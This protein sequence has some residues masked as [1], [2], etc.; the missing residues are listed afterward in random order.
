MTNPSLNSTV[1][2]LLT[3]ASGGA[4][5]QGA[6]VILDVTTKSFTT[7]T[8]AGFNTRGVGVVLDPAG[9]ANGAVGQVAVAGYVPKINLNAGGT[10]GDKVRTHTVAG[11]GAVS[12][13]NQTGDF[14]YIL[15]SG[16]TPEAV[17]WT[18]PAR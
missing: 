18:M 9:I 14:G 13:S 8:I 3:N 7:T 4:V 12:S 2:L 16:T 10:P 11:Q 5:L 1:R 17:L 15:G 6:V